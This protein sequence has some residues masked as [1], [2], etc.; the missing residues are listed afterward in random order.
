M[1]KQLQTK[2]ENA[3][4][5]EIAVILDSKAMEQGASQT[6]D[7]IGF[8]IENL[9]SANSRIDQAIKELQAIK[10]DNNYQI[11]IIKCGVSDWLTSNGIEKLQ[12]DR[13]SS[14]SV[15]DKKE[16]RELVITNEEAVINAGYF[17]MTVDKASAKD[18]LMSGLNIEGAHL[19]VTYN[20]PSIRLNKKR[21]KDEKPPAE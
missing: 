3:D 14:I 16:N 18:A 5:E 6:V 2:L 17:K 11:E 8:A 9:E 15:F 7:Y 1:L 4:R 21:P 19:E 20:E 13:I 10:K 12:G